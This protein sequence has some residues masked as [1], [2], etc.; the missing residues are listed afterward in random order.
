MLATRSSL[1]GLLGI[2]F[3]LNVVETWAEDWVRDNLELGQRVVELGND[4]AM[5][6]HSLEG[7]FSFIYHDVTSNISVI[8][9]SLSYFFLLPLLALAV[10]IALARREEIG[11]F[12]VFSLAIAINYFLSLPFFLF[13]PVPERWF[14]SG[15]DA[16][17]LS[18]QWTTAL[19]EALRPVSGLDNSFPS[20]HVSFTVIIM[21]VCFLF[22]VR[23]RYFVLAL[24]LTIILS[25]Y[26]LGIHW[27]ADMIAG[28]AIAIL[29]VALA[30]RLSSNFDDQMTPNSS[31]NLGS[32]AA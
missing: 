12:R 21:V 27:I 5:A 3:V 15:S 20:T 32:S 24:G 22:N 4:F 6:S 28:V 14:Y 30:Y 2:V 11:P 19:I 17:L 13:M 16:M 7:H 31:I 1:L 10:G 23:L 8:G 18:D 9:Y 26:L 25:T 29:S